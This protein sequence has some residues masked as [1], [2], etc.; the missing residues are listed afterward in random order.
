MHS[1]CENL[2]LDDLVVIHAGSD[3]YPLSPKI[4][5]VALE[6]MREDVDP[7]EDD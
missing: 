1:A 7:L 6:R 2:G 3:S 4:R 5:A